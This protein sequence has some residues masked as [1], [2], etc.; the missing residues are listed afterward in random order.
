MPAAVEAFLKRKGRHAKFS[1]A[2]G[3]SVDVSEVPGGRTLMEYMS[4]GDAMRWGGAPRGGSLFP[5]LHSFTPSPPSQLMQHHP[6]AYAQTFFFFAFFFFCAAPR[7][8]G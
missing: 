4:A 7:D 1:A 3:G 2:N 8:V 5:P 6:A